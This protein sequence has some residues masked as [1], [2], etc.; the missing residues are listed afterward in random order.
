MRRG[1]VWD[2]VVIVAEIKE[3]LCTVQTITVE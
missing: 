1:A 2:D 3:L